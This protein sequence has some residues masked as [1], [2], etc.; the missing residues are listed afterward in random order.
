MEVVKD[1]CIVDDVIK[2]N[3]IYYMLMKVLKEV[4]VEIRYG[5][6]HIVAWMDG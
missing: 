6:I 4:E 3:S 2:F 5:W 1:A